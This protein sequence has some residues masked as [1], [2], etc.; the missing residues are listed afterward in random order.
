MVV[1][2]GIHILKI[3]YVT[4]KREYHEVLPN[5]IKAILFIFFSFQI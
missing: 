3:D 4:I 5:S 2:K 1:S